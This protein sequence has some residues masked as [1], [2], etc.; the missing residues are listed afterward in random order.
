M[1]DHITNGDVT[2]TMN[3]TPFT[4]VYQ[5]M[6]QSFPESEFRIFEHQQQLLHNN[7]YSLHTEQDASGRVTAL[8]A[9]WRLPGFSFI[10]HLAVDPS[11]RGGGVGARLIQQFIRARESD[12]PIILEVEPP[13]EE[14]AKRRIGFYER[15]GFHLNPF[16][17]VQP[18]LREGADE[19]K[20]LIMSYPSPLTPQ[21]FKDYRTALYR[22]VYG[23]EAVE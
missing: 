1:Q 12:G 19:L 5:L 9:G 15:L 6:E 2:T 11:L 3:Y 21:E 10:E 4:E 8:L 7:F 17:Y 16:D 14:M 23:V 22:E 18:P 20:L 13:V